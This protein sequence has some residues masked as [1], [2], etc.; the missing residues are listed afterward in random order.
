MAQ[1]QPNLLCYGDNLGF[2]TDTSLFPDQCV[3]LIYLDPL[4]DSIAHVGVEAAIVAAFCFHFTR[5]FVDAAQ[6]SPV[7]LCFKTPIRAPIEPVRW[8]D[9]EQHGLFAE[10]LRRARHRLER[11]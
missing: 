10:R 11:C 1:S 2:L 4:F 3:D 5:G 8:Q 9:I 6:S 7:L